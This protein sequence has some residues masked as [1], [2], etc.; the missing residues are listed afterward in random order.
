MYKRQD[1][2]QAE[3]A[4]K[5]TNNSSPTANHS[6]A[7]T[8]T[9]H[10]THSENLPTAPST[11]EETIWHEFQIAYAKLPHPALKEP[12]LYV[13]EKKEHDDDSV[14][15]KIQQ[16]YHEL[17]DTLTKLAAIPINLPTRIPQLEQAV[18]FQ[19]QLPE[20]LRLCKRHLRTTSRARRA[21]AERLD[22]EYTHRGNTTSTTE[23]ESLDPN[24]ALM[25]TINA[26]QQM[27]PHSCLLY[28][29]PSP[30]D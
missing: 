1:I 26:R 17:K 27:H 29:S 5:K 7:H 20:Y 25:R 24:T 21:L 16:H 30:R 22:Q 19:K 8:E 4:S 12:I 28:T 15:I 9:D 11:E 10:T 3:K 6:P 23:P 13:E 14:L 18:I 2:R